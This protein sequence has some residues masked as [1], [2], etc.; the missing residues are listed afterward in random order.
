MESEG[1]LVN[2]KTKGFLTHPNH[3]LYLIVKEFKLSFM[4]HAD[5]NDVFEKTYETVLQNYNIKLRWQ[6]LEHK[7]K[8]LTDVYTNYITMRMRQHS[9]AKNQETKKLN[10]TKKKISKLVIS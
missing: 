3:S 6:C 9:S 1:E 5:S 2:M 4:I 7:S 10:K 8:I